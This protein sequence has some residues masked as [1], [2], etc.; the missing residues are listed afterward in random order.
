MFLAHK[1]TLL[2]CLVNILRDS[3][4]ANAPVSKTGEVGAAPTPSAKRK[5]HA[6]N[7]LLKVHIKWIAIFSKLSLDLINIGYLP[8]W[9]NGRHKGLLT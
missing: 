7:L 2:N 9:W 3:I 8:V 1:K 6:A 4:A 5:T